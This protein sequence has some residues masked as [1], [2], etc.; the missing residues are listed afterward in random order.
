MYAIHGVA[1]VSLNLALCSVKCTSAPRVVSLVQS[2]E[3]SW[4]DLES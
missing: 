4:Y 1:T 2:S 3:R